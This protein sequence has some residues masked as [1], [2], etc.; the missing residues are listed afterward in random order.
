MYHVLV[1]RLFWVYFGLINLQVTVLLMSSQ[2]TMQAMQTEINQHDIAASH[3]WTFHI[4]G[5]F[6]HT[7][8]G[9]PTEKSYCQLSLNTVLI[10]TYETLDFSA[11]ACLDFS[12]LLSSPNSCCL[13]DMLV[14]IWLLLS[15]S[16]FHGN[17]DN[18]NEA[19]IYF[20]VSFC[21]FVQY[22]QNFCHSS[23]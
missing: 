11:I 6:Q 1:V 12:Q 9:I 18:I 8:Y 7:W 16:F 13:P 4:F 3:H 14:N 15:F 21:L 10:Y 22:L 20:C 23:T 19:D 2:L 5:K 17:L